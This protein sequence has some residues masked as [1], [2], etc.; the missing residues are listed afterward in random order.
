MCTGVGVGAGGGEER[1]E[2]PKSKTKPKT[3][4]KQ[5]KQSTIQN[6]DAEEKMVG[7]DGAVPFLL[8]SKLVE[9]GAKYEKGD[10][11]TSKVCTSGKIVTG[12]NPQSSVECAKAVVGLFA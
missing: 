6:T 7:L 4:S 5:N 9:L 2:R 8:E 12:Q 10:P 3:T 1:G 11:W